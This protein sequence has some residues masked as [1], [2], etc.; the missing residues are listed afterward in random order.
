MFPVEFTKRCFLSSAYLYLLALYT[1][2]AYF[3]YS[4]YNTGRS[5][6]NYNIVILSE[7]GIIGAQCR[8]TYIV[9][10]LTIVNSDIIVPT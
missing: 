8:S 2:L 3:V 10:C 4:D 1:P 6:V 9:Y 5:F 7:G